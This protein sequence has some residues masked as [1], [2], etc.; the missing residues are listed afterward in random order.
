MKIYFLPSYKITAPSTRMRV[1]RPVMWLQLLGLDVEIIEAKLT[2]TQKQSLL[3]DIKEEDILYVQKWRTKFNCAEYIGQ[4]K[5]KCKIVF[6]MDDYTEDPAAL[7]L[8]AVA[9]YLVVGNHFLYDLYHNE[10]PTFI[11]P[12]A[13]DLSEFPMWTGEASSVSI[14]IAKC[15][16]RPMMR[17]LK[18]MGSIF[19]KLG[20]DVEFRMVLAGFEDSQDVKNIRNRFPHARCKCIRLKSYIE[21]FEEVVPTLQ[22]TTIG[23]LPFFEKDNGKSGHSLLA[24]MAMGIPTIATPHAE[25]GHIIQHGINGFLIDP[26]NE[27]ADWYDKIVTLVKNPELRH[28]FRKAAWQTIANYYDMPVI[29]RKLKGVLES[30]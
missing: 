21:Y 9:D 17:R 24:N 16:I 1:Y 29:A 13:V 18:D 28:Q 11:I 19:E 23:I 10:K 8:I 14:S 26:H 27:E 12:T 3:A 25:C 7:G 22:K 6:D 15:G 4:Y 2:T 20:K 30:L 5:G